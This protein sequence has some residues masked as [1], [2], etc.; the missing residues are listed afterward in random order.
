MEVAEEL[1]LLADFGADVAIAGMKKLEARFEGIGFGEGEIG[2]VE[3]AECGEEVEKPAAAGDGERFE[4][5]KASVGAA[6]DVRA[7]GLAIANDVDSGVKGDAGEDDIA[8]DPSGAASL[9]AKR[10]SLFNGG[11]RESE[12]RDEDEIAD[13]PEVW[14]IVHGE[15]IGGA[16]G[17]DGAAHGEVGGVYDTVAKGMGL[18]FELKGGAA[19]EAMVIDGGRIGGG[20]LKARG[21]TAGAEEICG[22]PGFCGDAGALGFAFVAV[23]AGAGESEEHGGD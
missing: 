21:I 16:A 19:G 10:F 15:E 6:D 3:I 9:R 23:E 7:G 8:A 13:A 5:T 14:F 17:K 11:K 18:G 22:G 4:R 2:F 20:R 1:E 12:A